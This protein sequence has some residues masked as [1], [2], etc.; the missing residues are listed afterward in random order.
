MQKNKIERKS[1]QKNDRKKKERN[2][3]KPN[4]PTKPYNPDY[5]ND[6]TQY[7]VNQKKLRNLIIKGTKCSRMKLIKF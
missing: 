5:K 1:F 7:K 4:K 2:T 3:S 6:I